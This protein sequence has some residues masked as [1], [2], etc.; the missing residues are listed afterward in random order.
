MQR[1]GRCADVTRKQAIAKVP[2]R[3]V[4]TEVGFER[5]RE[6]P[7][8]IPSQRSNPLYPYNVSRI[9]TW[10]SPDG[11]QITRLTLYLGT[12]L[13]QH[14]TRF[15]KIAIQATGQMAGDKEAI[16]FSR[17]HMYESKFVLPLRDN[18][19][20]FSSLYRFWCGVNRLGDSGVKVV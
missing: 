19:L 9:T 2:K 11:K 6:C 12:A 14:L 17:V 20:L 8:A 4:F 3:K 15:N 13:V 5:G 18:C 16:G 10:H 7:V 1:T